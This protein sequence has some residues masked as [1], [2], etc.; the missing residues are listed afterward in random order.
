MSFREKS[1]K[2]RSALPR[3][4]ERWLAGE[5]VWEMRGQTEG[6]AVIQVSDHQGLT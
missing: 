1:N 2:V 3:Q 6:T 5:Q 4:K